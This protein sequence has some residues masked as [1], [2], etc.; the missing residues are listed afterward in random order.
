[1]RTLQFL[2][3]PSLLYDYRTMENAIGARLPRLSGHWERLV[4]A[5][6]R[7]W[8][9]RLALE[10]GFLDALLDDFIVQPFLRV[11]RWCDALE[12]RWTDSLSG[13][14]KPE[15]HEMRAAPELFEELL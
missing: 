15:P 13:G 2:R 3:A 14:P 5:R 12:R 7:P 9:Y 10:R 11:F 1:L 4:P 6:L 8:S